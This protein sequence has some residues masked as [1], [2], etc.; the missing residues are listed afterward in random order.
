M[1]SILSR[2]TKDIKECRIAI[3][4]FAGYMLLST[5]FFHE[6]CPQLIVTGLPCPG[7]GLTRAGVLLLQG[8]FLDAFH[9][10]AFI[11]V[12]FAFALYFLYNHYIRQRRIKYG[13]QIIIV[14][15]LAML[16][17]YICRMVMYFPE[18]EPMIWS[19]HTSLIDVRRLIGMLKEKV[20]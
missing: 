9:M 2:I 18:R 17:Y 4:A 3:L 10:H 15:I 8:R 14:L 12:W 5:L 16:I 1:K 13:M 7:C 6:V 20:F 11:Y 19:K